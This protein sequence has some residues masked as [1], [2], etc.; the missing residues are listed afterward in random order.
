MEVTIKN[1][2]I[3][4]DKSDLELLNSKVWYIDNN[5]Y[6]TSNGK[7]K[8]GVRDKTVRFHS[9]LISSSKGLEIDHINGNPLD[10]RKRNLRVVTHGQNMI[11]TRKRKDNTSGY[12]GVTKHSIKGNEYWVARIHTNGKSKILGYFKDIVAAAKTYEIAAVDCF[13]EYRRV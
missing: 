6:L 11:N 8:N 9:L 12:K 5:G 10:N 4:I 1:K 3:L 7:M 2:T 13:G